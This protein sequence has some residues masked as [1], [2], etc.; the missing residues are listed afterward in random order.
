MEPVSPTPDEAPR[1]ASSCPSCRAV[2][3]ADQRYC[4]ACGALLGD[5]RLD[6]IEMLTPVTEV[7]PVGG[8]P[9]GGSAASPRAVPL[10]AATAAIVVAGISGMLVTNGGSNTDARAAVLAAAA[11]PTAAA[12]TAPVSEPAAEDQD[13]DP[14][15]RPADEP[16]AEDPLPADPLPVESEAP[17]VETAPVDDSAADEDTAEDEPAAESTPRVW[18]LALEG[19]QAAEAVERIEKQGVRLSGM[20]A[21]ASTAQANA[22]ALVGGTKPVVAPTVDPAAAA[23]TGSASASTDA[24]PPLPAALVAAQRT[25]RA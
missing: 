2:T 6:P 17:P 16:L 20:E 7:A 14:D 12:P 10:A 22:S 8:P 5:R 1:A 23:A 24:A 13:P 3:A 11:P 18:L 19:P 4:L 25:W 9:P 21:V 15:P